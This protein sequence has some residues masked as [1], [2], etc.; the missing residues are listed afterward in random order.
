[1]RM[2][3]NRNYEDKSAS[4]VLTP[5]RQLILKTIRN[6]TGMLDARE[7]FKL[8]SQKDQ[9]ISLATVY[10]SLN[11]FKQR[12]LIDEH[13]MGKSRCCFELKKSMEHQRVMCKLC[14]K[15]IEFESPLILDLVQK[16]QSENNFFIDKVDMCIQGICGECRKENN[17]EEGGK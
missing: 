8:V 7:L 3:I 12:D 1:M 4:Y 2:S 13:R 16:L 15:I 14:G 9:S 6:H 17:R 5:Q 10:R 11:L